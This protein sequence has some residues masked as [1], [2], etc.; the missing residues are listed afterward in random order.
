MILYLSMG[1]LNLLLALPA[2]RIAAGYQLFGNWVSPTTYMYWILM[3]GVIWLGVAF[4]F[5]HGLAL[6]L[7]I[8]LGLKASH[9][10]VELLSGGLGTEAIP[11]VLVDGAI[12]FVIWKHKDWFQN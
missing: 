3:S 6:G 12:L 2:R 1:A 5:Q 11:A 8:Y 9:W 7:W 10:G 4:A